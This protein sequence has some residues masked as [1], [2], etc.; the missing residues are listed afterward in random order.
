MRVGQANNARFFLLSP[1]RNGGRRV[2]VEDIE[3]FDSVYADIYKKDTTG[4]YYRTE[5][6]GRMELGTEGYLYL[7]AIWSL[8]KTR[9]DVRLLT[10]VKDETKETE[11]WTLISNPSVNLNTLK[12]DDE[13]ETVSFEVTE[14]GH[15]ESIEA[16][17][18]DEYDLTAEGVPNMAYV[19][20]FFG[21]RRILKRT[22]YVGGTIEVDA[23]DDQGATARALPLTTEYRSQETFLSDN[24]NVL[25]NSQGGTYAS[26][27]LPATILTNAPQDFNYKINGKVGIEVTNPSLAGNIHLDLVRYNNG[28]AQDFDE[29]VLRLASGNPANFGEVLEYEFNNYELEVKEGDSI[30]IMTLSDTTSFG[31]LRLK[32]KVTDDTSFIF[33]TDDPSQPTLS[34]AIKLRTAFQQLVN[35]STDSTDISVEMPVFENAAGYTNVGEVLLV[36][37]SWIRNMPQIIN[38]G[39]DDERR[40]Q[41]NLSLKKLYEGCKI[42]RPLRYEA[43]TTNGKKE[44]HVGLE[45]ETQQNFI[46]ARLQDANGYIPPITPE[47]DVIGENIYGTVILGSTTSGTNYEEVNNLFSICGVGNWNTFNTDSDKKYEVT[48]EIRTGSEDFELERQFQFE[49]FPDRDTPRQNDW[50][51]VH[52][53]KVGLDYQP[54]KWQDIYEERPKNV[55]DADSNF[56]WIFRPRNLLEG[57]GWKIKSCLDENINNYLRH[58]SGQNYNDSLIT[59]RAG[60][61]ERPENG[62]VYHTT[63]ERATVDLLGIKFS[64]PVRQN[65]IQQLRGKTNGIDNRFGLIAHLYKGE[66]VYSRLLEADLNRDGNFELIP[67]IR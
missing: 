60:E 30:G 50:F 45:K 43:R 33:S 10:E 3:D 63:L 19:N 40:V 31:E 13:N 67:A 28:E 56:N 39:E 9:A 7:L 59:K 15:L 23:R 25:A 6:N 46:G 4:N 48:T 41:T 29:I 11:D 61:E 34:K 65:I 14:G 1:Q 32:Y 36:H 17:W 52:A 64:L 26:L 24:N 51:L 47:R 22:K 37:G 2:Q 44:F 42:L 35:V 49:D 62:R 55:Y 20:V 27:S 5:K 21:G 54:V 18:D 38:E 16:R 57:H 53:K 8:Y 12:F 66:V 58:I